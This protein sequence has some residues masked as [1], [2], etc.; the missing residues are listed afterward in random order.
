MKAH[1]GIFLAGGSDT[2]LYPATLAILQQRWRR[3]KHVTTFP[4]P[5]LITRKAAYI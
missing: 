3:L 4:D 5:R 2:R 1:K